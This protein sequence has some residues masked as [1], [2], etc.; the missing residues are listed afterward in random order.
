MTD[1]FNVRGNVDVNINS[2]INA[3][4]NANATF[5]N[6]KSAKEIIGVPLR[7]PVL[8]SRNMQLR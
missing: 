3:Y 7:L 6:S 2:F 1:R 4:I 8:I 5:Y